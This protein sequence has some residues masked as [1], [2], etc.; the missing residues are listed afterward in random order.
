MPGLSPT[1]ILL[2]RTAFSAPKA[3]RTIPVS[4]PDFRGSVP[5]ANRSHLAM[6]A[7]VHSP[8]H[9]GIDPLQ[10]VRV[11]TSADMAFV[12]HMVAGRPLKRL[13]N[14]PVN[15]KNL[16][17]DPNVA[18]ARSVL[19]ASPNPTITDLGKP[20]VQA[21]KSVICKHTGSIHLMGFN[22]SEAG[23]VHESPTP[24]GD[25]PNTLSEDTTHDTD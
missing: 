13:K 19:R 17:P 9:G 21:R 10:M 1:R 12:M 22:A 6:V 20:C 18:V 7:A 4:L 3:S 14:K 24:L 5:L 16:T 25:A 2:F 23:A 8:V 11:A 15:L